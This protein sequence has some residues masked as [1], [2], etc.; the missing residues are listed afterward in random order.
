MAPSTPASCKTPISCLGCF[1]KTQVWRGLAA[2]ALLTSMIGE[3]NACYRI[4]EETVHGSASSGE[5]QLNLT[6]PAL[7]EAKRLLSNQKS[8]GASTPK[9][10]LA[11]GCVRTTAKPSGRRLSLLVPGDERNATRLLLFRRPRQVSKLLSV[12]RC[13]YQG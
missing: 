5:A 1:T 4:S 10:L 6:C 9:G 3:T 13:V 8:T 7:K 11:S 2:T 12:Q